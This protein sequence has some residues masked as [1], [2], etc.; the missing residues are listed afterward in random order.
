[1][2]I[3]IF[4]FALLIINM[5]IFKNKRKAFVIISFFELF[6]V[7]ALRKYTIGIDLEGHYANNYLILGKLNWDAIFEIIKQ[8]NSFYDFGLIIFMKIL[9]IISKSEQ[10]FIIVTSAAIYGLTGRYISKHSKNV[11]LETFIF[12]TTYTY[13]MY[14][15]IIAQALALAI[16][17]FSID[18]LEKKSYIKFAL[19]ILLANCIHSS[20]IIGL[21][22]IPLRE[23]KLKKNSIR[24][25]TIAILILV[26]FLDQILPFILKYIY[27]QFA[28][29]F[30]NKNTGN[31]DKL[32]LVH[33]GLYIIFFLFSI[34]VRFIIPRNSRIDDEDEQK[35]L[36]GFLFYTGMLSIM[37]R[38]LGMRFYIFS[39]MGFYFYVFSYTLFVKAIEQIK[40][41]KTRGSIKI[42]TYF[43]M[44][45]FFCLL[46]KTLNVSYGVVPYEFYW[47]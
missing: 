4:L 18:F 6:L 33:M 41:N 22:F 17:L 20:A 5:F 9:S 28:Y 31:L 2:L 23:I 24:V 32:Q 13:F 16:I 43:C 10:F 15:N 37:F 19:C 11:C 42:F 35:N 3:Y 34:I 12:F 30:T 47:Q 45:V 36:S 38:Y 27:P 44:F 7:A 21:I 14:M 29:Y 25:L 46:I 39:R 8:G 26:I 1:M 40:D